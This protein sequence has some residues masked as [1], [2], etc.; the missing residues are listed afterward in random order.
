MPS[1]N[2][3][4]THDA[5]LDEQIADTVLTLLLQHLD[6]QMEKL[7]VEMHERTTRMANELIIPQLNAQFEPALNGVKAEVE[8]RLA[9]MEN[10][11][12]QI[13]MALDAALLEVDVEIDDAED[14]DD[15]DDEDEHEDREPRAAGA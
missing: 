4:G 10:R 9:K 1:P 8:E 15:E 6:E 5:A 11:F 12:Q 7:A 14:D 3:N 2:V 13:G